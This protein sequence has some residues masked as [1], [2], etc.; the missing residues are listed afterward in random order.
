MVEELSQLDNI[1]LCIISRITAIPPDCE[2]LNIPT[3]PIEAARDAFYRIYKN[4]G[5]DLADDILDQLDF[6]PLSI[7]LL[8]T[9]AHQNSWD[10]GRLTREW[11]RQ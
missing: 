7:T 9:V 1:C 2:A 8:A 11:E 4:A 6:H 3:L 5:T 10:I